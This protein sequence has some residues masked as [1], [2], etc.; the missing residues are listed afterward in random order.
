[1]FRNVSPAELFLILLILLLVFGGGRV[2]ELGGALGKAIR[3]FR[4]ELTGTGEEKERREPND[5]EKDS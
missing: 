5:E 1:M 3:E 2:A 4:R